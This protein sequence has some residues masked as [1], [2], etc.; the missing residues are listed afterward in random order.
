MVWIFIFGLYDSGRYWVN[1]EFQKEMDLNKL[2]IEEVWN[3]YGRME[4]FKG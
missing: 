4:A 2:L 1:G 3:I